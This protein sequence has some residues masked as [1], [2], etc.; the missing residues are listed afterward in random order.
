MT[1]VKVLDMCML[2]DI[3][4]VYETAGIEGKPK[5]IIKETKFDDV[6]FSKLEK[7]LDR[8]VETLFVEYKLKNTKYTVTLT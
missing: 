4:A 1:L 8:K 6:N 7:H 5:C 3:V 2:G